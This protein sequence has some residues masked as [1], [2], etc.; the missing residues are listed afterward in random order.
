MATDLNVEGFLRLSKEDRLKALDGKLEGVTFK[1]PKLGTPEREVYDNGLNVDPVESAPGEQAAAP[2]TTEAA[3]SAPE[4][5]A[6][7]KPKYETLEEALA[8]LAKAE[9]EKNEINSAASR[10]GRRA[11]ELEAETARLRAE[12]AEKNK[13]PPEPDPTVDIPDAPE[14]PEIPEDD[15]G[16]PDPFDPEY[17]GKMKEYRKS[18]R[19]WEK[20]RDKV[21]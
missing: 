8:A 6:G 12:L 1:I 2:A 3:G 4:A 16:T 17:L 20:N 19:E 14:E 5:A 7:T 15:N 9:E 13:K 21:V 10:H 18:R 11:A